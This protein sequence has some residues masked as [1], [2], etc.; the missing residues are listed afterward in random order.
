MGGRAHRHRYKASCNAALKNIPTSQKNSL[1]GH[2]G[3]FLPAVNKPRD[4]LLIQPHSSSDVR[5]SSVSEHTARHVCRFRR[6]IHYS[7][8]ERLT[9]ARARRHPQS[10]E[11]WSDGGRQYNWTFIVKRSLKFHCRNDSV[12]L[13]L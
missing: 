9:P 8:E 4:K 6:R 12:S 2:N 7:L 3:I 10:Y 5:K 11:N 1:S 13:M